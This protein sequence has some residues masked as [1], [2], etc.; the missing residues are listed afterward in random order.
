MLFHVESVDGVEADGP[1]EQMGTHDEDLERNL[2]PAKDFLEQRAHANRLADDLDGIAKVFDAGVLLS[3]LA[4][5]ETRPGGQDAH[6]ED[7]DD[8]GN[9]A[10]RGHDGGQ[11]Q[12][13]EGD[14]LG[15]EDD[16]SLPPGQGLEVDDGGGCRVGL[17]GSEDATVLFG[18]AG[19]A[20]VILVEDA[21]RGAGSDLLLFD[22][23]HSDVSKRRFGCVYS[24]RRLF[25]ACA[26]RG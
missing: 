6:N 11:R 5:H 10:E 4:K 21:G 14:G 13:T 24:M 26:S 20:V 7:E 2:S 25:V 15:D 8:A 16:A 17:H 3:K 1:G 22:G 19:A 12:D 18:V 23:G 9:E